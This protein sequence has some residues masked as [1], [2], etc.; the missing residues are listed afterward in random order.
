MG[1]VI[2]KKRTNVGIL[3]FVIVFGI[4]VIASQ[5]LPPFIYNEYES[6]FRNDIGKS[7]DLSQTI[8]SAIAIRRTGLSDGTV[9]REEHKELGQQIEASIKR[10]QDILDSGKTINGKQDKI[11]FLSEKY[12]NYHNNKKLAFDEYARLQGVFL[13]KK[14]NDHMFTDT[15]TLLADADAVIYDMKDPEWTNLTLTLLDK[16]NVVKTN[17]DKL[18]AR[19]FI[20]PEL[21]DYLIKASDLYSYM[22]YQSKK[23]VEENSWDNY[24][25]KKILV[26]TEARGDYDLNVL[27]KETWDIGDEIIAKYQSEFASND[28]EL[29]KWGKYYSD[30]KLAFDPISMLLSKFNKKYPQNLPV[31]S[32]PTILPSNVEPESTT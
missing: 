24:D 29:Y 6:S 3:I 21:H 30:E 16:S 8:E 1:L 18:K 26:L 13:I 14:E 17:A 27:M 32:N 28:D 23:V 15:M 12:R 4:F 10:V 9:T 22:Y 7:L 25:I 31:D 20:T 11:P 2:H 5:I 19:S